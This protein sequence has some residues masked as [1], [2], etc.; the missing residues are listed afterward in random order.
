M[1]SKF[2]CTAFFSTQ[3]RWFYF[4]ILQTNPKY[5]CQTVIAEPQLQ[6]L[7]DEILQSSTRLDIWVRGFW[8]IGQMAYIDKKVLNL[9]SKIYVNQVISKTYKLNEKEKKRL[10]IG[11]IIE[12]EH[13]KFTPL[14]M[15]ATGGMARLCKNSFWSLAEMISS[16]KVISYNITIA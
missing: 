9:S 7:T 5:H 10:Y 4:Y 12:I 8:Q 1:W 15:S 3:E 16:K 13:V 14:V 11:K 2:W 6:K